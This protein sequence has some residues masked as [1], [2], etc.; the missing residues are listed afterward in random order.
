MTESLTSLAK[1]DGNIRVTVIR[2]HGLSQTGV[3]AADS[4][5]DADD[6]VVD[7]AGYPLEIYMSCSIDEAADKIE[8]GIEKDYLR[9]KDNVGNVH[10]LPSGMLE[11]VTI[12]DEVIVRGDLVVGE[13]R[14][15]E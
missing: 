11:M 14:P 10:F 8:E 13:D 7:Y 2:L 12:S 5:E 1:K 3:F 6:E 4:D 9:L 15:N